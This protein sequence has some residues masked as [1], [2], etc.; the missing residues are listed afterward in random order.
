MKSPRIS[1]IDTIGKIKIYRVDGAYIRKNLDGDFSNF[2]QGY[3]FKFIPKDE[4][5]LDKE[6]KPG[7][8]RFFIDHLLREHRLMAQ[9][10]PY[11]VALKAG[12]AV[13]RDERGRESPGK[14]D[15][16]GIHKKM[17]GLQGKNLKISLVDGEKV[18]SNLYTDFTEGGHDKC[19]KFISPGEVWLD[20]DNDP[21]DMQPILLHELHERNLMQKGMKYDQAHASANR[22]EHKA[23]ENPKTT[24]ARI[25]AE[26]AESE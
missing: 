21:K 17:Y 4:L 13:E 8:D 3:R 23:R 5:W 12:D 18:R 10:K 24:M 15:L 26:L 22:V 1:L 14:G 19:Y 11:D 2:G 16:T 7:E 9:G 6:A 20:D 25:K